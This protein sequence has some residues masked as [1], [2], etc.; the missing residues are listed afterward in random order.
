MPRATLDHNDRPS[1]GVGVVKVALP[2]L[3][4]CALHGVVL[5]KCKGKYTHLV[6]YS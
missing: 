1:E 3:K 2:L 6:R 5:Q 4:I